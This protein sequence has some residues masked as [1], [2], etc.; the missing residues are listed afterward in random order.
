MKNYYTARCFAGK[1][2]RQR[3]AKLFGMLLLSSQVLPASLAAPRLIPASPTTLDGD[4]SRMIS[5]RHQEHMWQTNDGAIHVIINR[6]TLAPTEPSLVLYSSFDSGTSW[7]SMLT[8]GFSGTYS[9]ADGI[10]VGNDLSLVY[11]TKS[12]IVLFSALH[13]DDVLKIWSLVRTEKVF[14]SSDTRGINPALTIDSQGTVWCAF[15]AVDNNL[16]DANIMLFQQTPGIAGW[17]DT[18]LVFGPTDN[19]SIERSARPVSLSDGVGMIYTVH[20]KIFWAYRLNSWPAN[21]AW[22]EQTLFTSAPPYDTDPYASHFS[23]AADDQKNLHMATVDHGRVLYFRFDDLAQAWSPVRILTGNTSAGYLQVTMSPPNLFIFFNSSTF[24]SVVQSAD[25]G[26]TF[27]YPYLLTHDAAPAGGAITYT[28]PRMEA[29]AL[30]LGPIP[31]LQQYEDG[32][33]QR[34]MFFEVPA[35]GTDSA[36]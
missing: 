31:V 21:Q 28:K 10:L 23:V 33:T 32:A 14:D 1:C 19:V 5:Y 26:N 17:Q 25:G 9:T 22:A 13:Y 8:L 30:S 3:V 12:G 4:S 11:P 15:V 24:V 34:A 20:D 27:T 29:P 18:G 6:G 36:P 16:A 7:I 35:G 2:L